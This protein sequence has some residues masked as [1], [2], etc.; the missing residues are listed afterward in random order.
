MDDVVAPAMTSKPTLRLLAHEGVLS[1]GVYLGA[2]HT[3]VRNADRCTEAEPYSN[4]ELFVCEA[5][6][7]WA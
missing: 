4:A 1:S 2:A 3:F 7:K 6:T 5:E